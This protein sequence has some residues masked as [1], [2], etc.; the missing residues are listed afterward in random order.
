MQ[1][2]FLGQLYELHRIMQLQMHLVSICDDQGAMQT[3]LAKLEAEQNQPLQENSNLT[4]NQVRP[5]A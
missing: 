2:L 4:V 3:E 5:P 1:E